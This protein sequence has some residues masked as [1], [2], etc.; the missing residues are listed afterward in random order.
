MVIV[1]AGIKNKYIQLLEGLQ[2]WIPYYFSWTALGSVINFRRAGAR[3]FRSLL[4]DPLPA[5]CLAHATQS[6]IMGMNE[7]IEIRAVPLLSEMRNP[8]IILI[9]IY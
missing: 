5:H 2:M 1:T 6:E 9:N 8:F 4:L 7:A 3:L